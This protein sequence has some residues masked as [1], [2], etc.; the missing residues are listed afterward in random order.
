MVIQPNVVEAIEVLT[1]AQR[2][3]PPWL[4]MEW[5]P[6]SLD[7]VSIDE[8]DAPVLLAQIS[9]GLA[10]MHDKGYAH[11]DLKP[12]NIL[13]Q[14]DGNNKPTT[15]KIADFGATKLDPSGQMTTYV[16]TTL[17]MAP[18][19]SGSES[20]YTNAV[21]I[22]SLGVMSLE[23]LT[24]WKPSSDVPVSQLPSP[25]AHKDWIRDKLRP[26]LATAPERYK[27]LLLGQL[28][29]NPQQRWTANACS[30]W[31][32]DSLQSVSSGVGRTSKKRPA[33]L[34]QHPDLVRYRRSAHPTLS[35]T[36]AVGIGQPSQEPG[37][38]TMPD[39]EE[40]ESTSSLTAESLPDTAPWGSSSPRDPPDTASLQEHI[41]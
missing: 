17:Y 16:G 29:D 11:R 22:W 10:F 25:Q 32:A 2:R 24:N 27:P 9:D 40:T 34:T 6:D 19:I 3:E 36:R 20:A 37:C 28:C 1:E 12:E 23:L 30:Q 33:S 41:A 35:P 38:T 31:L 18:E 21:D 15:A 39:Q 5:I 13:V 26:R 4:I 7:V 14:M 8:D